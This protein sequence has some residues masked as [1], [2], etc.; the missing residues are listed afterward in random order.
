MKEIIVDGYFV[1]NL[2]DDLFLKALTQA[3]PNGRL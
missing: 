3:I 1:K 2:G